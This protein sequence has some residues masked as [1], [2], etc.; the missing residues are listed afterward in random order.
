[1]FKEKS[2]EK[3]GQGKGKKNKG[4]RGYKRKG[5]ISNQQ[6]NDSYVKVNQQQLK[7]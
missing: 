3:G 4:V 6:R 5:K 1:M 2:D 7:A